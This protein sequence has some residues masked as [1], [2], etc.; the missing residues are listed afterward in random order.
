MRNILCLYFFRE[1]RV[2][3]K[4]TPYIKI[5]YTPSYI[6]YEYFCSLF[7]IGYVQVD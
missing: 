5:Y 3:L 4:K 7:N 6:E 1:C 2:V